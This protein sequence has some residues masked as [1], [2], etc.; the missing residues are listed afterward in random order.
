MSPEFDV[1]N[2]DIEA[3]QSRLALW[4]KRIGPYATV[5]FGASVTLLVWVGA[6][7]YLG[8]EKTQ[9]IEAARQ[10]TANL[11]R[12]FEEQIIR[13]VRAVDQVLLYVRDAY[14]SDPTGFDINQWARN[15]GILRDLAFQVS[16]IDKNGQLVASNLGQAGSRVDLSDRDHFK[17]HA[18]GRADQP[19]ISKP[20]IGRVSGKPSIKLSRRITM[21][22]SSF[23]GVAVV[24]LNPE[25]LS[26]F[27]DSIDI[28]EGGVVSLV[29]TDG[30]VRARSVR[31]G[32]A[33]VG[34]LIAV[35]G[36]VL[37][38]FAREP[39]GSFTNVSP[40]D[41]I[42]R[43]FSYRGVRDLPLLVLVGLA[44]SE[45]FAA[46]QEHRTTTI[47]IASGLTAWFAF[48]C[49][50]M[51][52]YQ[53]TL[54]KAYK[55]AEAGT[56]A[57]SKFLAMMSHELRT[58]MN[59]VI[60]MSRL[61]LDTPLNKE[62]RQY[63]QTINQSG[64]HL[65]NVI[66]DILDFSRLEAKRGTVERVPFDLAVV[67]DGTMTLARGLPNASRLDIKSSI[68]P[69]VPNGL[70]GDSVLLTQ[71]LLNFLS[72]AVKH[73]EEGEVTVRVLLASKSDTEARVRFVVQDTGCGISKDAMRRLFRPFEQVERHSAGTGLGLA[74]CKRLVHLMKGSIGVDSE[75]GKGSTFWCE[76]P[77][78]IA[79][80]ET[81]ENKIP[82]SR[83]DA[84][85]RGLNVL[86]VEDVPANQLV[87]RALMEN[88][89]HHVQVASDGASAIDLAKGKLFDLILMDIQMPVMNG[90]EATQ[91]IRR[92]PGKRGT[93]PIV[94]LT[95][96]AQPSDREQ[97]LA[98]GMNG[99]LRKPLRKDDLVSMINS[100]FSNRSTVDAKPPDES[101]QDAIL[102]LK[103]DFGPAKLEYL[104]QKFTF[105]AQSFI[106]EIRTAI[107]AGAVDD[108][109]K[110][111]HR[112]GGLFGQFGANDVAERAAALERSDDAT[113]ASMA[114]SFAEQCE[115]AVTRIANRV[116]SVTAEAR[117]AQ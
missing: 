93:I 73:T 58:P 5:A 39:S 52:W 47:L 26:R 67:I 60:G 53:H 57:R 20:I 114:D 13:S 31:G 92:L 109:R 21:P 82:A 99:F 8:T 54:S 95:A 7:H 25:Y 84:P 10:S 100:T 91:I 30:I 11:T 24:S 72:N 56:L 33:K 18:Q 65:L 59:A 19:F 51:L 87:I 110:S 90:Y 40:L 103:N 70:V 78:E 15:S 76:L 63:V 116:R 55:A 35:G 75:L 1:P 117:A 12:A 66:N 45:I 108:I 69:D 34:E 81:L 62:Q 32:S 105:D 9:A 97:A 49:I 23:G 107:E 27:Y 80:P 50:V 88:L 113:A 79:R 3:T 61:L 36:K 74:I 28:G 29:G 14:A 64:D 98:V 46:Y 106:A 102:A 37:E 44:T 112:I 94:A 48:V 77:F 17:V 41:G 71:V 85:V 83:S 42:E 101:E 89:G 115:A 4:L 38:A 68:A 43:I 2:D 111:A 16:I 22:D 104:F 96:F 86:V 6:F